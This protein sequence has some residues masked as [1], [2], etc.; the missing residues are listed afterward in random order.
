MLQ[1]PTPDPTP[2]PCYAYAN[3]CH[4]IPDH[5]AKSGSTS[6]S[7]RPPFYRGNKANPEAEPYPLF[8]RDR[9]HPDAPFEAGRP[10]VSPDLRGSGSNSGANGA[11][12]PAS[13]SNQ[14]FRLRYSPEYS[15][16][17]YPWEFTREEQGARWAEASS[18]RRPMPARGWNGHPSDT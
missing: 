8:N 10:R 14:S 2:T 3:P 16:Y 15:T 7:T 9:V 4:A 5:H 6:T 17:P 12:P 13:T 18:V 1:Y 11:S